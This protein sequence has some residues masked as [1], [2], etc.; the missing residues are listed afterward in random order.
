MRGCGAVGA[1]FDVIDANARGGMK[2][3]QPDGDECG[4]QNHFRPCARKISP[5]NGAA[6]D[7]PRPCSRKT[8]TMISGVNPANHAWPVPV[9]VLPATRN[10]GTAAN[11]AL[12]KATAPSSPS[13]T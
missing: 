11:C 9:P 13:N 4:G 2:P 12:P 1:I 8:T 7:P 6:S 3:E 5:A 10:A